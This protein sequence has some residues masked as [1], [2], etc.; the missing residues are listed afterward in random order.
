MIRDARQ[1]P[2]E[3]GLGINTVELGGF[4]QGISDGCGFAA[5]LGA[6]E[7]VIFAP[8]S[9]FPFI[10]PMSVRFI[11]FIIDVTRISVRMSK[12]IRFSIAVTAS[13]CVLSV[14]RAS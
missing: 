11:G 5:T 13:L 9:Q 8:E 7:E 12:S 1:N 14:I 3:P 6:D 2:C 4:D 10:L